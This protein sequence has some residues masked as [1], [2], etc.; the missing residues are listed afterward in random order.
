MH[1]NGRLAMNTVMRKHALRR[2]L[3][4][5]V[6]LIEFFDFSSLRQ[7]LNEGKTAVVTPVNRLSSAFVGSIRTAQLSWLALLIDKSRDGMDAVALWSELFPKHEEEINR[8]WTRIEPAWD[9]IRTFRDKAGFHADKPAAF[10]KAR[11]GISIHRQLVTD[12]IIEFQNLLRFIL[13]LEVS[14]LPDLEQEVDEFLNE[15]QEEHGFNPNRDDFKRY[16]MIPNTK[17]KK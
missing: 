1:S 7:N 8:V 10:F 15:M 4:L 9:I 16:L 6:K 13:K 11:L 14:E 5:R 3:V 17:A 2:Y 12:A